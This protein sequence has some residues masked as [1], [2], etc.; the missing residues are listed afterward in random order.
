MRPKLRAQAYNPT[1]LERYINI[2]QTLADCLWT[3][4]QLKPI[5]FGANAVH[6]ARA[7]NFRRAEI[8]I[9][10]LMTAPSSN[11]SDPCELH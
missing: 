6:H 4:M 5:R 9:T 2:L 11:L 1:T 3:S 7:T 10:W 8:A